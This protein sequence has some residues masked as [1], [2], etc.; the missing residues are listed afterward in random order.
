MTN[1][2]R[3]NGTSH[4]T[5]TAH[6]GTQILDVGKVARS[7]SF[8]SPLSGARRSAISDDYCRSYYES[9]TM[10][11]VLVSGGKNLDSLCNFSSIVNG[12]MDYVDV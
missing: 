2:D 5:T 7:H 8:H 9:T 6:G 1:L 3:V 10:V 12:R 4:Q 11:S